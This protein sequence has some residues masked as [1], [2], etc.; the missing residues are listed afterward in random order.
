[1]KLP[2]RPFV[3][4]LIMIIALAG[5]AAG[6]YYQSTSVTLLNQASSISSLR[7]QVSSLENVPNVTTTS[8]SI[9]SFTFTETKTSL[10]TTTA[11]STTS[12]TTTVTLTP[13]ILWNTSLYLSIS[14][15]CPGPGKAECWTFNYSL[16]IVFNCAAAAATTQGCA[17]VVNGTSSHPSYNI[18]IWYPYVSQPPSALNCAYS[19]PV[20]NFDH[21]LAY[22]I[23]LNRASFIVTLPGLIPP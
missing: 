8:T 23:S 14:A 15:G 19:V 18:T 1:M 16:A 17:K 10:S 13:N 5:G 2:V 4:S 21:A 3:A 12:L 20:D 6:V 9:V 22:C 7:S 11:Y